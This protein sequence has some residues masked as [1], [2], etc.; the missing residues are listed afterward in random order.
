[1]HQRDFANIQVEARK[2][3]VHFR[4]ECRDLGSPRLLII[5][6]VFVGRFAGAHED[7]PLP[8]Q[9]DQRAARFRGARWCITNST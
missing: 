3:V 1:M 6:G 2:R 7:V 4:D 9:Q 5:S 8:R